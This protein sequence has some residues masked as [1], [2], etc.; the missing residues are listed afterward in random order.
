MFYPQ[1]KVWTVSNFLCSI[2][3]TLPSTLLYIFYPLLQTGLSAGAKGYTHH[4][5]RGRPSGQHLWGRPSHQRGT[6]PTRSSVPLPHGALSPHPPIGE[7]KA[8]VWYHFPHNINFFNK[9]AWFWLSINA[10]YYNYICRLSSEISIFFCFLEYIICWIPSTFINF[11]LSL[12]CLISVF[13]F[14]LSF[15]S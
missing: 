3:F 5:P 14:T 13:Q 10:Y 2:L 6:R 15:R 8:P 9:G 1:I 4:P 12:L 11:A 7:G